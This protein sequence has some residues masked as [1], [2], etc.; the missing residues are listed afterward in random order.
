MLQFDFTQPPTTILRTRG[1]KLPV[2]CAVAP[3]SGKYLFTSGKEGSI[4]KWDLTTGKRLATFYKLRPSSSSDK[5]KGRATDDETK[6]HTNEVLALS[7][8]SDGKYLA[9]AGKDC[10]LCVWDVEKGE[11]IKAFSGKLGHKDTI[12]VRPH[13]SL[14]SLFLSESR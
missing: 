8:S 9:S 12:S 14:C 7:L 2:T 1:H 5:G 4:I 3:D 11:W 6:G 13:P 10:K